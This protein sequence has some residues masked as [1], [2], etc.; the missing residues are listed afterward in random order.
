M[1]VSEQGELLSLLPGR[2]LSLS[3]RNDLSDATGCL[4]AR[5]APSIEGEEGGSVIGNRILFSAAVERAA[6]FGL[7]GSVDEEEGL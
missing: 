4:E 5:S 2:R 1:V 7:E 3:F 6:L